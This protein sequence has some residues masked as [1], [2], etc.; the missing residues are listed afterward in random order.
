MTD[1]TANTKSTHGSPSGSDL[2]HEVAS[3]PADLLDQVQLLYDQGRYLDAWDVAQPLGELSH[4]PGAEGRVLA[5]R[6]AANLGA[7]R[8]G[9]A[10]H[11]LAGRQYPE[12]AAA[13]Y[14][15][16]VARWNRV[17]MLH[18]WQQV[19]QQQ[20]PET[21]NVSLKADWLALKAMLLGWMRDFARAEPLMIEALDLD[22][23]SPWLQ[24]Q[25][26]DLLDRQ[27][28][29]EDSLL[30]AQESLALRPFF[31]PGVQATA[32]RLVQLR[33]DD[34]ALQLLADAAT[35][36]QSGDVWCQLAT[37]QRELEDYAGAWQSLEKAQSLWPLAK[38]D[39]Q[40]L[41]WLAGERCDLACLQGRYSEAIDLARQNDRPFYVRL[42]E[43]LTQALHSSTAA[44]PEPRVKLP[45]PYVRQFH[46]TCVP[47]TLTAIANYWQVPAEQQDI[48]ERICYEGTRAY[49]ERRW[50]EESGFVVR[51]F[52]ITEENVEQLIRARVPMT[53][54][55]VD[56]GYAH[57]QGIVGFDRYRGTF[58]I[59]DPNERHIA[60]AATEK[61]LEHYASTGPRG[62]LLVP[63]AESHRIDQCKLEDAELYDS[64]YEID[65]ALAAFDRPAAQAALEPM[66][67]MASGHRLTLQCQLMLARY[68]ADP[69]L[70]L[71][72]VDELL[73]QFP[74][75]TNLLLMKLNLLSEFGQ[76]SE[77]IQLL[78]TACNGQTA[79][80]ILWARLAS[81]LLDD[82]RDYPEAGW[83]LRKALRH[84]PNDGSTIALLAN[85]FWN[86]ADREQAL[87][88]YR[89][90]ASVN[91]KDEEQ[92]QR[93]FM[94]A[95][96]LHRTDEALAWLRDRQRRFGQLKSSPGRTL[97]N[98]L[99]MLDLNHEAEQVL[100][101]TVEQH[102]DDGNLQAS[103]ALYFGR[104][105][106]LDRASQHLEACQGK[107]SPIVLQRT[108]ANL[109]MLAGHTSQA[110]E[111]FRAVVELDPLDID[112]HKQIVQLELDL[113]GIDAAENHLRSIVSRFPHSFSLRAQLILF[114]RQH[115]L[116]EVE[117]ELNRFIE[118]HPRDA[119]A[120]R[121]AALVALECHDLERAFS[122]ASLALECDPYN[123]N[124]QC[125]L[126][127]VHELRGDLTA[128]RAAYR[129][130]L[131]INIDCELAMNNLVA[132]CDRPS[133]RAEEL[134][135]IF[136]HLQRQTT[137]G[138][139]LLTY[140]EVAKGRLDSDTLLAQL[141]QARSVRP[142]LWQAW[143]V[144]T[145]QYLDMHQRERA[146]PIAM[147]AT[148][149]FPMIP[150]IWLDLA[151]VHRS[152]ND[153]EAEAQALQQARSINPHWLDVA[154]AMAELHI[155]RRQFAEAEQ[156]LRHVLATDPRDPQ[157]LAALADCLYHADKK[158]EAL[159]LIVTA[160]MRSPT[161]EWGWARLI[162]WSNE[163]DSG[164]TLRQTAASAASTWPHDPFSYIRVAESLGETEQ[165]AEVFGA[166]DKALQLE[167]RLITA[168]L[169]KAFYLGRLHRW[170][171]A[172]AACQPPCFADDLPAA[173]RVRKAYILY[174]RGMAIEAVAE[175]QAALQ[176]DADHYGAWGQLADWA[177]ELGRRDVYKQAAENLV[178]LNP[179]ES[180]PH[181]YLADA[182][183]DNAEQRELAKQHLHIAIKLSPEYDY[184]T[185][186]LFDLYIE[187]KQF[188]QAEEVLQLGGDY[189]PPGYQSAY[190][191][192]LLA[193][194]DLQ[195][196]PVGHESIEFL[197]GWLDED[198]A[199]KQPI[200]QAVDALDNRIA[201]RLITE[202]TNKIIALTAKK[203]AISPSL[204][205]ALG[206][207][208]ARLHD[209]PANLQL[210]KSLPDG[211]AWHTLVGCLLGSLKSFHKRYPQL[212]AI[213]QK[214]RL[215]LKRVTDSWYA[216]A[217][218]LL[219]YG[220]YAEVV[221]WTRDWRSYPDLKPNYLIPV[222]VAR[223]ETY[224]F[225]TARPAIEHGLSLS[226]GSKNQRLL[227]LAA[228]DAMLQR[229]IA[230]AAAHAREIQVQE[231]HGWYAM[232]YRLVVTT[233][234]ALECAVNPPM[235]D[236]LEVQKLIDQLVPA[237]FL[238]NTG[239]AHDQLAKWFCRI[240]AAQIATAHGHHLAAW[241]HRLIAFNYTLR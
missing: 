206:R 138:G 12:H 55:T 18:A 77:R 169:L 51:E 222:I 170:D 8:L 161:F 91:D 217:H 148:G 139:A 9:R 162:D 241:K 234:Q 80:P 227:V 202:L 221:K 39:S 124:S 117:P 83:Q 101:Q 10:L 30:A 225:R 200:N 224:Q 112:A 204:G 21:A 45:V 106:Q 62:M 82:A 103:A 182:L 72:L 177:Q 71:Q 154:R 208:C 108:S 228:V 33:R 57:S 199:D 1:L 109:A 143:S 96:Y 172:L 5:G 65:R 178:R 107:C 152:A 136:Q 13:Q 220:K 97:S 232:A 16:T 49:D 145:H 236:A 156:V 115:K 237:V 218:A 203:A 44:A 174:A 146:L 239:Y 74:T 99:E 98:A 66:L 100:E 114:L 231:L 128:A 3:S 140:R 190:R 189:L 76:R 198:L 125:I 93:Y 7:P 126:G 173:L 160:C 27:D 157:A 201:F 187:D 2:F 28:L 215:R 223:F 110:R 37:L 209:K 24:V 235:L 214:Y 130:A 111:F 188:E 34:E 104:Y 166:L 73:S 233:V 211:D 15:A 47:A 25:L 184:A 90:A 116:S 120:R 205:W 6:L 230:T 78:R 46:D 68:D 61:F 213:I 92:S 118:L 121:E 119:W 194:K 22:P 35:N 53:L 94:A 171:E 67:Q 193:H 79:H 197:L 36:L 20:L 127:R 165:M 52:R 48:A 4:W 26:S 134:E 149:K 23:H 131:E 191:S 212:E 81:E 132:I 144:V 168:H 54:T 19:R 70:Q 147:E 31:R 151:Y 240:F 58:L 216:T 129:A 41:Q 164:Q 183:L 167:P 43:R 176:C 207:L 186:R 40:H 56:P 105:N 84:N 142:D 226:A 89:L 14:Y 155:K 159:T 153:G 29:H 102:P 64:H 85:Y 63:T 137:Y 219:E 229:D 141:E 88:L 95:R 17:G 180:V 122:E 158:S 50:A 195:Q 38:A 210:L 87:E 133:Q 181:G 75:D 185:M 60:E 113:S 150:R 11:W 69:T 238:A 86:Q 175:M 179:H 163:L 135:F 59:Q 123:E 32:Y 196:E 192:L 42:V